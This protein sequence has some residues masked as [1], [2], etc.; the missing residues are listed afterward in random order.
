MGQVR[1][2][3]RQR[4]AFGGFPGQVAQ[5]R[6]ESGRQTR[7]RQGRDGSGRAGDGADAVPGGQG[8]PDEFIAGVVNG[9]CAGIG[10]EGHIAMRQCVEDCIQFGEFVV[11]EITGQGVCRSKWVSS[12]RVARIFG[13]DEAGL[14][15]DAQG[16]RAEVFQVADGGGDEKECCPWGDCITHV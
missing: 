2:L 14:T 15:Q 7:G 10:D 4:F 5:V 11:L 3:L 6:K 8:G 16:A 12:L 9:G 1:H 13:G